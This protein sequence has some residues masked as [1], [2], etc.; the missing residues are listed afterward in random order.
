M[1]R[2]LRN[3]NVEIRRLIM[4]IQEETSTTYTEAL[5]DG[6]KLAMKLNRQEI[7]VKNA[8]DKVLKYSEEYVN[9]V[10]GDM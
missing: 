7:S 2:P 5:I 1:P 3:M 8:L 6:L 10:M 4:L 9:S